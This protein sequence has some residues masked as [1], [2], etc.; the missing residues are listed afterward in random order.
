MPVYAVYD[1]FVK[2][3]PIDWPSLFAQGLGQ[4]VHADLVQVDQPHLQV[5]E[6][7]QEVD[8]QARRTATW[9]TDRGELQEVFVG[10]WRQECLVKTPADYEI[11]RRA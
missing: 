11:L 7:T 1:W 5:V 10:E 2:H 9:R 6:T 8:G 3:R 4:I